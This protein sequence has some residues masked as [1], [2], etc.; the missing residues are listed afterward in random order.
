MFKR[1][2][3]AWCRSSARM[4]CNPWV[5]VIGAAVVLSA[6]MGGRNKIA[7][8]ESGVMHVLAG[9]AALALTA[10]AAVLLTWAARTVAAASGHHA[11]PATISVQAPA[12]VKPV[13]V[14]APQA[15]PARPG[16][17]AYTLRIRPPDPEAEAMAAEADALRDE[18]VVPVVTTGGTLYE[19][20]R[21]E[22]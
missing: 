15:M 22:P 16:E 10:V 20:A 9:L 4:A 8:H 2:Y 11:D 17:P 18:R 7:G 3:Q 6:V 19:T 13:T 14:P 5:L 1:I 21:R 12:G